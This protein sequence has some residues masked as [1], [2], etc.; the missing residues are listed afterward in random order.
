MNPSPSDRPD[1]RSRGRRAVTSCSKP[2]RLVNSLASPRST[3]EL[4]PQD[5][6]AVRLK[7]LLVRAGSLNARPTD[8]LVLVALLGFADHRTH[9]CFPTQ[10]TLA[11]LTGQARSTVI[12]AT[13][14]LEAAGLLSRSQDP[15]TRAYTYRLIDTQADANPNQVLAEQTR[16]RIDVD[17]TRSGYT[18]GRPKRSSKARVLPGQLSLPLPPPELT[19]GAPE[20]V[21]VPT[22]VQPPTVVAAAHHEGGR[23]T[24]PQVSTSS[25]HLETPLVPPAQRGDGAQE[26]R[27][28]ERSAQSQTRSKTAPAL[29]APPPRTAAQAALGQARVEGLTREEVEP[30]KPARV[31]SRIAFTPQQLGEAFETHAPGRSVLQ[32][33]LERRLQRR[34]GYVILDLVRAGFGLDDVARAAQYYA[35]NDTPFLRGVLGWSSIATPGRLRDLVALSAKEHAKDLARASSKPSL[36]R[37][38]EQSPSPEERERLLQMA[39]EWRTQGASTAPFAGPHSVEPERR[40]RFAEEMS[41]TL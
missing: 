4:S 8:R 11:E 31:L 19:W 40:V 39:R 30:C 14:R 6:T 25:T 12:D 22:D 1:A 37:R 27:P 18:A 16:A 32:G 41:R 10:D 36:V 17:P 23:P 7:K 38:V 26:L 20:L 5:C 21:E 33:P 2:T 13:R 15:V 29:I 3:S 24:P 28:T 9:E 35:K 34:V